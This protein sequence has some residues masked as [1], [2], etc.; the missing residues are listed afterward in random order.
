M[1]GRKDRC[2]RISALTDRVL[3]V[4]VSTC[5]DVLEARPAE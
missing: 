2:V 1:G 3:L 5:N 4:D